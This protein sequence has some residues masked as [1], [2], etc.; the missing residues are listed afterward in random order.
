MNVQ[1]KNILLITI[2]ILCNTTHCV[3]QSN[4]YTAQA[5]TKYTVG[6]TPG[7]RAT[8]NVLS[9]PCDKKNT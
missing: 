7:L 2:T 8:R 1:N 5:L 3:H 9:H 4:M 6:K